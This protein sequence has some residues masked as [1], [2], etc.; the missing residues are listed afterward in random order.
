[1][2]D[3]M[4]NWS[5]AAL[6]PLPRR[7]PSTESNLPRVPTCSSSLPSG[8]YFWSLVAVDEAAVDRARDG[9]LVAPRSDH[10]A[11]GVELDDRGR[12]D[13]G[14]LLLV[15]DVAPVHDVDGVLLAHADAAELAG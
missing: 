9:L 14:L 5:W 10:V 13:R 2:L 3:G 4:W 6:S 12:R 15:G 8:P 11:V 1:M 7:V